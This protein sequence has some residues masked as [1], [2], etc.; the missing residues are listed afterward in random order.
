[1]TGRFPKASKLALGPRLS[2]E[3]APMSPGLGEC[4][5][6]NIKYSSS[7]FESAYRRQRL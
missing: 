3:G 1:M 7:T 4:E 2:S 5:K 6:A